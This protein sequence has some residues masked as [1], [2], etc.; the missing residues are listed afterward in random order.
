MTSSL[1]A[2]LIVRHQKTAILGTFALSSQ[3]NLCVIGE[4]KIKYLNAALEFVSIVNHLANKIINK[5]LHLQEM[6]TESSL[7]KR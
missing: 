2:L 4:K 5:N 3:Y 1:N 7:S 6:S